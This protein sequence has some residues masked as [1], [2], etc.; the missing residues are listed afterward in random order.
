MNHA[1]GF[2]LSRF[3]RNDHCWTESRTG[4]DRMEAGSLG[5]NQRELTQRRGILSEVLLRVK[6]DW[7]TFQTRVLTNSASTAATRL[8]SG[9]A[10]HPRVWSCSQR[11]LF[12][13]ETIIRFSSTFF[14]TL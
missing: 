9:G 6:V 7:H 4:L 2:P 5:L 1:R 10:G 3:P 8:V 13:L 11:P 12:I 14:N